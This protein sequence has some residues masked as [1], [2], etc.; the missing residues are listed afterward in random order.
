MATNET[1]ISGLS[2]TVPPLQP[3][4]VAGK[5]QSISNPQYISG[6]RKCYFVG[7]LQASG[8]TM[9][10]CHTVWYYD[11]VLQTVGGQLITDYNRM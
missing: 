4:S 7:E 9:S 5:K 6:Y 2:I 11:D 1:N 3:G 10:Q 8:S